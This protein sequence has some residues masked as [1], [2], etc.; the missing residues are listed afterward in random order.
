MVGRLEETGFEPAT[1][2]LARS[3]SP[4][5]LLPHHAYSNCTLAVCQWEDLRQSSSVD[6]EDV[7]RAR[8]FLEV[9][10]PKE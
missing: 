1:R 4:V 9:P 3:C 5:E 6:A 2:T 10:T 8:Q 7:E